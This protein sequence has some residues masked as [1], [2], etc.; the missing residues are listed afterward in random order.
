MSAK[1]AGKGVM[2]T[3]KRTGGKLSSSSKVVAK[4]VKGWGKARKPR[5]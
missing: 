1:G 2:F 5:G 3:T 4:Q